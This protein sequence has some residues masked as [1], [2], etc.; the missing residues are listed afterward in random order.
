[1]E[2][3]LI[4]HTTPLLSPGLI[5]GRTDVPL[6]DSFKEEC[7]AI[8]TQLPGNLDAVLSSPATRCI[9]LAARISPDYQTDIRIQE[10]DFG[11]WEGKTW[12]TVNQADLQLWMDDYIHVAVPGG[13]SM[14]QMFARVQEFWDE[15]LGQPYDKVAVVT[16]AGVIRQILSIIRE[17]PLTSIFDIKVQYGEVFKEYVISR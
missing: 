3:Y 8:I 9:T 15:L 4:R 16:H 17:I 2:V 7:S 12:D 1:M 11:S 6:T 14:N 10:L 5:Y 13:E